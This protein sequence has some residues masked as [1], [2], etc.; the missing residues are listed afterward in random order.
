MGWKPKFDIKSGLDLTIKDL[1]YSMITAM[2]TARD[3]TLKAE[4]SKI[5][6]KPLIFYPR[7]EAKKLV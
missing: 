2:L 5:F 1:K 4:F 6:E 3:N 7:N